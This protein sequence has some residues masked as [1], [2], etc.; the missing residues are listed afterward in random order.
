MRL[1]IRSDPK[2]SGTREIS[3]IAPGRHS[4]LKNKKTSQRTRDITPDE[5]KSYMRTP[6]SHCG[7]RL[8]LALAYLFAGHELLPAQDAATSAASITNQQPQ[9]NQTYSG[10]ISAVVQIGMPF[11][12]PSAIGGMIDF[13]DRSR[14]AGPLGPMDPEPSGWRR[15]KADRRARGQSTIR[16]AFWEIQRCS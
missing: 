10:T 14:A 3:S 16:T 7:K 2:Y 8:L 1:K 11:D 9:F 13:I 12:P 6:T 4:S 5:R 15:T